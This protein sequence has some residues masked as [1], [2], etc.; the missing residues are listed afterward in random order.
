MT[1]LSRNR[2]CAVE[3]PEAAAEEGAMLEM[4]PLRQASASSL[5]GGGGDRDNGGD[6]RQNGRST[7]A[8]LVSTRAAGFEEDVAEA[9]SKS[10]G[11]GGFG[12]TE[13]NGVGA[14]SD[15]HNVGDSIDDEESSRLL[16]SPRKGKDGASNGTSLSFC[17]GGGGHRGDTDTRACADIGDLKLS[18]DARDVEGFGEG[19]RSRGVRR[20]NRRLANSACSREFLVPIRLLEERRTRSVMF[21][22]VVFSVRGAD[23]RHPFFVFLFSCMC[24]VLCSA[25]P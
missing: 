2:G 20:R 15:G 12:G 7:K 3:T 21:V 4:L 19:S 22:Y 16:G 9:R 17:G 6:D 14:V 8:L 24:C 18:A 13:N 25:P 10:N 1:T 11:V 5:D 23:V